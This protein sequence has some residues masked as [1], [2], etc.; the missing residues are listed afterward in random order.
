MSATTR[1]LPAPVPCPECGQGS[2]ISAS[3]SPCF[4]CLWRADQDAMSRA[5]MLGGALWAA[6]VALAFVALCVAAR[7]AMQALP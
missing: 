7:A 5:R 4:E 3:G 1:D 6:M 2:R